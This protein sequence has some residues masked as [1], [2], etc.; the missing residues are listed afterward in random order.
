MNIL[1]ALWQAQWLSVR[2]ASRFDGRM[3]VAFFFVLL[4]DLAIAA[5]TGGQFREHILQWQASGPATLTAGLWSVCLLTWW[6]IGGIAFLEALR[7]LGDD[8]A[9]L[10][11]TLPIP[12]ATRL[13]ALYSLFFVSRL[14]NWLLLESGVTGFVLL[15]TLGWAQALAWFCLLQLGVTCVVYLALLLAILWVRFVYPGGQARTRVLAIGIGVA[16]VLC[17]WLVVSTFSHASALLQPWF[18][19]VGCVVLLVLALGPLAARAGRLYEAGWLVLQKRAR[20]RGAL[21]LPGVRMLVHQLA[22]S[23]TLT[24]ALFV[25]SVFSQSRNPL[26]WARVVI[27]AL[28]LVFTDVVHTFIAAY[29]FSDSLFVPAFATATALLVIAEQTPNAISGEGNRLQLYLTA[30]FTYAVLLRA[31][32]YLY[33]IPVLCEGLL[34]DLMLGWRY[35]LTISALAFTLLLVALA[36]IG[37]ISIAVLGSVWD[38]NLE[39]AVEGSMQILMQEEAAITPKRLLLFNLS[40]LFYLLSFWLAW[41]LPPLL[42]IALLFLLN[43]VLLTALPSVAAKYLRSLLA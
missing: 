12:A 1:R 32:L 8:T 6:G 22:R 43:V 40:G 24:G 27:V 42:A 18:I 25:K 35:G 16:W 5:W 34:I 10:L 9:Q 7:G 14:W 37:C 3:R 23:R 2:N 38:E 31:K 26:F 30:P 29:H 17:C 20:S 21:M 19:S 4:L 28:V 39:L 33:L 41:K 15:V 36:M 13:R 11:F